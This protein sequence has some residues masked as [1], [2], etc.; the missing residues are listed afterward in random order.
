LL[1]STNRRIL[2]IISLSLAIMALGLGLTLRYG[3]STNDFQMVD[4]TDAK[5]LI[6]ERDSID[7]SNPYP[8][9]DPN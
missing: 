7:F 5:E 2:N 6:V 8:T 9:S 3:Q 4:L 1:S